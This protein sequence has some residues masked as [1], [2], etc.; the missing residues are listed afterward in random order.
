MGERKHSWTHNPRVQ[1]YPGLLKIHKIHQALHLLMPALNDLKSPFQAERF[2]HEPVTVRHVKAQRTTSERRGERHKSTRAASSGSTFPSSGAEPA[3]QGPGTL[4]SH[5]RAPGP[6]PARSE[7]V[8][9]RSR[10]FPSSSQ[11]NGPGGVTPAPAPLAALPAPRPQHRRE[12]I[13]TAAATGPPRTANA[14]DR[15]QR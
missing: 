1:S 8:P 7:P 2:Y 3:P 6:D 5:T 15:P 14:Q 10:P 13:G 9:A 11:R 12:R 4:R